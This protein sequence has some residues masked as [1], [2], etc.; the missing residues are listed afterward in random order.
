[1]TKTAFDMST[2][3]Q[4]R[5]NAGDLDG[6]IELL[7]PDA[8]SRSVRGEVLT[9]P[10]KIKAD[11]AGLLAGKPHLVNTPRHVLVGGDVALMLID[12]TLE[13]DTPA[14][15]TSLAG[16]TT[17]VVRRDHDGTWRLA[18]LNPTGTAA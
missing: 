9:D 15:R 10:E 3:F 18:V 4:D 13:V 1:M 7:A 5:V 14:G 12:W 8:V 11:L 6:L 17:N 2:A 16:T